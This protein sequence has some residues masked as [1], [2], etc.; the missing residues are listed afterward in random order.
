MRVTWDDGAV[1]QDGEAVA[2]TAPGFWGPT[3][4]FEVLGTRWTLRREGA[5][6]VA[7]REDDDR[8]RLD[9]RG[10]LGTRRTIVTPDAVLELVRTSSLFGALC[11]DLEGSS[12]RIGSIAPEGPWRYRPALE[13][14]EPIDPALATFVLWS[15]AQLDARRPTRVLSGA[16]ATGAHG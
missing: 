7:A 13:A 5:A 12:G 2:R 4:G 14:R 9:A 3:A 10:G 1:V 16:P 15:A 8:L 6:Y 11:F